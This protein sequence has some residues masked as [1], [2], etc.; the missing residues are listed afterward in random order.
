MTELGTDLSQLLS[1]SRNAG[2]LQR[3]RRVIDAALGVD[4]ASARLAARI[5][6]VKTAL[7]AGEEHWRYRGRTDVADWIAELLREFER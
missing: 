3:A 4:R 2:R 1:A 5:R 6:D 7:K